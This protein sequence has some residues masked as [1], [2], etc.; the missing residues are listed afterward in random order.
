MKTRIFRIFAI[1]LCLIIAIPLA[2]CDGSPENKGGTLESQSGVS[3]EGKFGDGAS[4]KAVEVIGADKQTAL[5]TIADEKYDKD[6]KIYVYDISVIK[7]GVKIQP[8]GKVKVTV[9]VPEIDTSKT[10]TVYHIKNNGEVDKIKPTVQSGK[11]VFETDG[12]SCFIIAPDDTSSVGG[13]N[14]PTK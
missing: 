14:E 1:I 7:D 10:Y 6:G 13:D 4:L 11:V 2:A 9:S 12:F 3:V 8:D 5:D